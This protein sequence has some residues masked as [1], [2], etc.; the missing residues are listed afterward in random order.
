ML[1]V[2]LGIGTFREGIFLPDNKKA[3]FGNSA[4]SGDLQIFHDGNNSIIK[5]NGTGA[6]RILGGNTAFMNAAENKNHAK[7]RAVGPPPTLP[8]VVIYCHIGTND[9]VP[10]MPHVI[11]NATNINTTYKQFHFFFVLLKLVIP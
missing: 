3:E 6:I 2:P 11:K 8:K 4:G 1:G 5:D 9:L 10:S 7:V